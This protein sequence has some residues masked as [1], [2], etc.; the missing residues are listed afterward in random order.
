MNEPNAQLA[1]VA[2]QLRAVY[3]TGSPIPPIRD[4][5]AS[6]DEAYAVQDLNTAHRLDAGGRLVGRKIGLTSLAVQRQLGVDQPDYGMLFADMAVDDGAE[7]AAGRLIQPKVEAEIA[8]VLGDD[9]PH[10]DT[11]PADVL[12]AIDFAVAA[13][14]IVDSRIAD[15]QI[16]FY[17]TVADNGSSGLYVLGSRPVS[18][19]EFDP[20]LCGMVMERSG[21][22]VSVGAGSACLGS[23]ISAAAWLARTMAAAGRPL[24]VGDTILSG[25]LGPMVAVEPGDAFEARISGLGSV[26]V[27]FEGASS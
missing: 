6:A 17:D 13:I 19:E 3:D 7:I 27:S 1:A 8:F 12:R 26:T 24:G 21:E 25:A 10:A 5:I 18:L 11:T 15:W 20:I 16:S 14:E 2:E 23:P 22:P 9:L 4:S